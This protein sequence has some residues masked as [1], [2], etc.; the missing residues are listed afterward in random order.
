MQDIVQAAVGRWHGILPQLGVNPRFLSGK[1]GPCPICGGKDRYRFDN[2]E[3]RGT[4]YCNRCGAGDGFLLIAKLRGSNFMG[5]KDEVAKVIGLTERREWS[6]PDPKEQE[7]KMAQLWQEADPLHHGSPAVTYLVGRGI[8]IINKIVDV[9]YHD[10]I[11]L[12]LFRAPSGHAVQMHRTNIATRER[13]YISGLPLPAGGA[14]RLME[15]RMGGPLGVAEGIETALSAAQ[16]HNIPC[17]AALDEAHLS[18]WEPPQ[19]VK[20][21]VIFGDND[22]NFVGQSSA[23]ACARRLSGSF[24]VE[25]RIPDKAGYDWNDVL[26]ARKKN[27]ASLR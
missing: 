12:A 20:N 4:W 10:G 25:V 22:K 18:K 19:N 14:V 9:R 6:K 17:W 7:Q 8:E 15:Y 1:Q 16:L 13:K 11:M 27:P 24:N 5:V 3:G 23:Y 21:I 26:Q 2:K